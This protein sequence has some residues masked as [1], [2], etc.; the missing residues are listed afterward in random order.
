MKRCRTHTIRTHQLNTTVETHR[1]TCPLF[2]YLVPFSLIRVRVYVI[3]RLKDKKEK[4]VFEE[5]VYDAHLSIMF[6]SGSFFNAPVKHLNLT[7]NTI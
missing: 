2:V 1:I 7:H 4:F 3:F 5:F 6:R